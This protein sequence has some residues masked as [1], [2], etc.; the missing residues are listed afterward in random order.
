M[1]TLPISRAE[2]FCF[3]Q[4]VPVILA[5]RF[6]GLHYNRHDKVTV[7]TNGPARLYFSEFPPAVFAHV[8]DHVADDAG[9]KNLELMRRR[10][11]G[12]VEKRLNNFSLSFVGS[13]LTNSAL[14]RFSHQPRTSRR[15][16]NTCAL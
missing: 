11:L 6:E 9:E 8:A 2:C 16:S 15:I 7:A 13:H 3:G 14:I 1:R 4:M 12:D 10:M 5:K